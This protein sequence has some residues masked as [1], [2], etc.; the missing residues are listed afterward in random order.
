MNDV[1]A[2]CDQPATI[3]TCLA[4]KSN[5]RK[6]KTTS[7]LDKTQNITESAICPGTI[8][9]TLISSYPHKSNKLPSHSSTK[10][11]PERNEENVDY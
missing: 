8:P 3:K 11:Q 4:D 2:D 10:K 5:W 6:S 1:G 9:K 7:D